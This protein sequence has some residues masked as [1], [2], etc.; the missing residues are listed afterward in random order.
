MEHIKLSLGD[1]PRY[2]SLL[3]RRDRLKKEATLCEDAYL[4]TFGAYI[5][6]IFKLE[7]ECIALKKKISFCQSSINRGEEIDLNKIDRF[8]DKEM[9]SYNKELKKLIL[10]HQYALS[11]DRIT[12]FDVL[13]I[14]KIYKEIAKSLH[15]DINP[16]TAEDEELLDLWDMVVKAYKANNLS[17]LEELQVLVNRAFGEKGL[18]QE[19]IVVNNIEEKIK[20][21]EEEID[22]ILNTDPYNYKFLLSDNKAVEAKKEEFAETLEDYKSYK[23]N[24]AK[25]MMNIIGG[26][27]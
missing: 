25:I 2:E 14:K 24:L 12:E 5:L 26:Q 20:K 18:D 1:Y 22:R 10:S 15:P 23:E 13:K 17:R 19:A 27:L 11:S 9:E 21:L 7:I 6:D 3:L 8:V 4:R 16:R